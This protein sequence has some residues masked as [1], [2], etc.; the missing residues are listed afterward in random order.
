MKNAHI[1]G[2]L[3]GGSAVMRIIIICGTQLKCKLLRVLA[4]LGTVSF[5]DIITKLREIDALSGM[6]VSL[7]SQWCP[8]PKSI[9]LRGEWYETHF[10]MVDPD[11]L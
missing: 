10:S 2:L 1:D 9:F 3:A 5:P 8:K 11:F 7:L 6:F 4:L